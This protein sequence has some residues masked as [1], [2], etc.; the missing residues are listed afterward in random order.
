VS[1]VIP[2]HNT[3]AY[4]EAAVQSALTSDFGELEVIVVDDGSRDQSAAVVAAIE[5][6]R[7]MLVRIPASGGPS[8]PR[9]VGIA[10]ARAPYIAF[11][12][13]DDL[14][15]SY[16]ISE[17]VLALERCPTAGFAFTDFE[18]ID[19]RGALSKRSVLGDYLAWPM[20][21]SE[22]AHTDWRIIPQPKLARALVYENFISTSG[23]VVRRAL[24]EAL[25]GFDESLAFS[26]DR[27]LWFRL[28]HRGDALFSCRVGVAVRSRPGSLTS[29]THGQHIRNARARIAV[30]QRERSRWGLTEWAIH[31]QLDRLIAANLATIGYEERRSRP[32]H[33][34]VMFARAFATS[35]QIR[36]LRG[37]LGSVVR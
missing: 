7:V 2:L 4:V 28:A 1:V 31:R 11:L 12:D 35:P 24:I 14:L 25:G 34:M 17:A 30:L 19:E 33:A 5:D 9:N 16:A 21:M 20:L 29:L 37:L 36:W 32:F 26:E 23:L 22:P 15:K 6:P 10:A 27:D 18:R 8:R 3:E 13:S